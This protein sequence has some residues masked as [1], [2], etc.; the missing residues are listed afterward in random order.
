MA[1]VGMEG[2]DYFETT[3]T[4][5][6]ELNSKENYILEEPLETST[7]IKNGGR[8]GIGK[9][10]KLQKNENFIINVADSTI[11][12]TI[13]VSFAMKPQRKIDGTTF[14]YI[15]NTDGGIPAFVKINGTGLIKAKSGAT[16]TI[17]SSTKTLNL[18][19]WYWIEIKVFCSNTGSIDVKVN[20]EDWVTATGD[21]KVGGISDIGAFGLSAGDTNF[22]F[23]DLVWQDGEIGVSD[24]LGDSRIELL[25]PTGSV[26]ETWIP[27]VAG[28][29]ASNVD[30][31]T[32]DPYN[33][34][35]DYMYT[36]VPVAESLTYDTISSDSVVRAVSIEWLAKRDDVQ[37]RAVRSTTTANTQVGTTRNLYT[38]WLWYQDI[39]QYQNPTGSVA[40]TQGT[41]GAGIS[42]FGIA[43][44]TP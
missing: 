14:F 31:I 11:T 30:G 21:T 26:S 43:D 12:N 27:F 35:D 15:Y 2:F 18:D 44:V 32:A 13:Y 4:N 42:S 22:H 7:K 34:T 6:L 10:L 24:Y 37:A 38:D 8:F 16:G 33:V 40:W 1:I 39:Y 20:G 23:D 36:N 41:I 17:G 29:N 19:I 28:S 5:Y 9:N 25:I 3:N